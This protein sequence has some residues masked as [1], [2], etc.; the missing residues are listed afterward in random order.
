MPVLRAF[1]KQ[2]QKEKDEQNEQE[3]NLTARGKVNT[4]FFDY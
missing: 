3:V 1:Q 2:K 4:Y